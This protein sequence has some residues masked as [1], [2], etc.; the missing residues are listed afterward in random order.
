MRQFAGDYRND[1]GYEIPIDILA[2]K[3]AEFAQTYT[4]YAYMRPLC[5]VTMLFGMDDERGPQL[6]KIDPA[7]YYYGC[8]GCSSGEKEKKSNNQ[9][10]KEFKKKMDL[11]LPESISLAVTSLMKTIDT[12]FKKTDLEIAVCSAENTDIKVLTEDEIERELTRIGEQD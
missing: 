7:G 4:Q 5:T 10:E 9:M 2:D 11:T 3:L 12:E 1:Y 6:F 8:I